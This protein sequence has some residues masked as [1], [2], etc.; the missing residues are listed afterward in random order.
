MILNM[1]L[2]DAPGGNWT[3]LTGHGHVLVEIGRNP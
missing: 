1:G 2:P 3:L